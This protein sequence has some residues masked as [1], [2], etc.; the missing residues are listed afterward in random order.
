M[1]FKPIPKSA[2]R[3]S[4]LTLKLD[5]E[6]ARRLREIAKTNGISTRD[7]A[8]QMILFALEN[9]DRATLQAAE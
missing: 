3:R 9:M 6:V 7:L 5:Q 4:Q 2:V 8:E 1:Q